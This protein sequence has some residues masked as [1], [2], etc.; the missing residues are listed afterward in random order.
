MH[1]NHMESRSRRVSP[2]VY[3]TYVTF[4]LAELVFHKLAKPYGTYFINSEYF[5]DQ[6]MYFQNDTL[7][8]SI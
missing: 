5:N 3:C 4:E 8:R 1:M 2:F 7:G 6:T